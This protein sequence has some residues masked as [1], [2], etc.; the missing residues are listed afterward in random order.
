M[1]SAHGQDDAQVLT[2][3]SEKIGW[4]ANWTVEKWFDESDYSRGFPSDETI[5]V[6]GNLLVSAG[7]TAL[8]TLLIGGGGTAYNAANTYLGVGS[9]TQVAAIGDTNL[10]ASSEK[11]RQLVESPYPTVAGSVV[12]F[13]STFGINDGNFAWNECGA[14]NHI[15]AGTMLNRKIVTLGTKTSGAVWTLKL[16]IT[17][18]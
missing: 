1:D 13:Q 5:E 17:I 15:S 12:T 2:G 8:L 10:V 14:F 7:I 3:L 9:S 16:T 11:F 18:S 4:K 6:E